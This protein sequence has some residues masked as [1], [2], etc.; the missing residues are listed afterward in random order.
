MK[1]VEKLKPFPSE[2][3]DFTREVV[4]EL[5]K[6]GHKAFC[7]GGC[8]R[9]TLLGIEPK[10]YDIT[11]SATP[12]EVSEIF[13]H[14][15]PIGVSF[16]VILVITGKYQFE[17]ATFRKDQSYTD[18]R[19]PDKVIYSS[20][21]QEDVRRRDFTING[22]LYDPIEEEVID[23]VDGIR[24]IKSK[25]VQTIGDPYERFN[26]D[27][28][29][30]MRA[31]RFSSRYNFELNLDTFLAIEKLAADITQVSSERIRDEITK[32]ITQ[33]N[34]GHGL[35]ML[36]V[37]GLL[38]YILP[39]VEIMTGVEQPPE[40]HPEGDV[41]I[42][43]CL[44]LDKLHKNQAGVVSPELAIGALLHDVGKPPTFSVSDRIRFNGHDKLGADMSKKICREL[45]FSNKQIE[46]IY[47]LIRDHLKFKDVFNM[48]KSTLKRF[49]GMPHFEEHMALH[50][51]DCQASHGLTAAYDFVMEKYNDFEE[52][53]IKPA[54]LISG[55]EL[56]EMGYK[57]G[58]LFSDIL[59]FVEEAQLEGEITNTQEAIEAVLENYPSDK[60]IN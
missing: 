54:P 12:E 15:V 57:P 35:N 30:M 26:E 1:H 3:L 59:N 56:I 6:A 18:G 10:E 14:T 16:G 58:P 52:E 19:H 36:S 9:D 13:P 48:K 20:E 46:V 55:R 17:V 42:H 50:L 40:F 11:T 31:I 47:A 25:I 37:S 4:V 41:F 51:A 2:L 33:S 53:E 60:Y 5:R 49:I 32:I 21:E 45:K 7:V 24:D 43:T 38:K 8:A 39:D 29:R 23:Y 34:P 22:M 27:K 28:L 44:V